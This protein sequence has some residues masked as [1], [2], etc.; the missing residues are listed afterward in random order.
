MSR[1]EWR[2]ILL[3]YKQHRPMSLSVSLISICYGL[4]IIYYH[5]YFLGILHPSIVGIEPIYLGLP[6]IILGT[7]KVLGMVLE[8]DVMRRIAVIG[9]AFVWGGLLVINFVYA[10]GDGYPNPIWLFMLRIIFDC[11]ILAAKGSYD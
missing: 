5:G 6:L 7:L 4:F 3:E 10:V 1:K 11:I 8:Y 2:K 9:L